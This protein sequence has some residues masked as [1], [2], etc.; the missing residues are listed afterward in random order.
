MK[1]RYNIGDHVWVAYDNQVFDG[2]V[3]KVIIGAEY[4]SCVISGAGD[5]SFNV[6]RIF[7]T[8]EEAME[9]IYIYTKENFLKLTKMVESL[10]EASKYAWHNNSVFADC[11]E[12]VEKDFEKI[13]KR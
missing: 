5:R 9:A 8:R 7:P 3:L 10:L 13:K 2:Y 11:V 1:T 12:R 4:E 6:E